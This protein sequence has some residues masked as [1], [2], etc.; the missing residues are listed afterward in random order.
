MVGGELLEDGLLGG[1]L[2]IFSI[3]ESI[4]EG[5]WVAWE[6]AV[7]GGTAWG[8][9]VLAIA[10]PA[11]AILGITSLDVEAGTAVSLTFAGG[12]VKASVSAARSALTL[13]GWLKYSR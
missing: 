12:S 4:G 2:G 8:V 3:G 7:T 11:T 10:A 13:A 9:A 5:F 1:T 6:R